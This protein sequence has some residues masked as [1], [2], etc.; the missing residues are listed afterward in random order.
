MTGKGG[1]LTGLRMCEVGCLGMGREESF[2]G[3]EGASGKVL[4]HLK[5]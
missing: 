2:P 3:R 4:R 1:V 5:V